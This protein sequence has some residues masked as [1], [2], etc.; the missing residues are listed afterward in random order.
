MK[1]NY[2]VGY[3]REGE[4]IEINVKDSTG[5]KLESFECNISDKKTSQNIL[6]ILKKKYGFEPEIKKRP[7]D[8][9]WLK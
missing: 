7:Q 4:T 2:W 9:D 5:T 6:R 1:K 8:L 3:K